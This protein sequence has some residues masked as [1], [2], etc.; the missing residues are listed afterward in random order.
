MYNPSEYIHGKLDNQIR[1]CIYDGPESVSGS[2]RRRSVLTVNVTNSSVQ[3]SP[4]A[5][6]LHPRARQQHQPALKHELHSGREGEPEL[7]ELPSVLQ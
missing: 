7:P 1:S 3:T 4:S 2:L 6:I 5:A